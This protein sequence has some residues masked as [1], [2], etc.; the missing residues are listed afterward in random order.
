MGIGELIIDSEKKILVLA[1]SAKF[2]RGLP[3][4]TYHGESEAD[5]Q[6]MD[7]PGL[8]L[9]HGQQ[10]FLAPACI[11]H[12]CFAAVHSS[13]IPEVTSAYHLGKTLISPEMSGDAFP[14]T[15]LATPPSATP[16]RGNTH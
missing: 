1:Y 11:T 7:G 3:V 4:L 15:S 13:S 9:D 2:T 14:Y 16:R 8:V 5:N 12:W 6:D 10:W